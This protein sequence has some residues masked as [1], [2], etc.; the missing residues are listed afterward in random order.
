MAD[1]WMRNEL[2]KM[3]ERIKRLE[4]EAGLNKIVICPRC[5]FDLDRPWACYDKECPKSKVYE[6]AD[7]C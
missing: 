7:D 1:L 3:K 5:G 4:E 2:R 6:L